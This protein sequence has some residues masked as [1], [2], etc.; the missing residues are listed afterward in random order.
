M[1]VAT[2]ARYSSDN[3][4]AA[5]ISDQQ[6]ICHEEVRR[7]GWRVVADFT[8]AALSGSSLLLR[9]VIQALLRGATNGEFDVVIA[10]S[11]DR[12]SRDQEDSA[13]Y[14]GPPIS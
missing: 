1:R 14:E 7:N 10:E 5:S 13:G 2:Y 11:L 9:P 4:R 12:L 8:D 3:Q 6:R